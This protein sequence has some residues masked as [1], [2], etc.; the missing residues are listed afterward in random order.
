MEV[1]LMSGKN[2]IFWGRLCYPPTKTNQ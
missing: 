2:R 1:L